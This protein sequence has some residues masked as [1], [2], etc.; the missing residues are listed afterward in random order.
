MHI[1]HIIK[2]ISIHKQFIKN[3]SQQNVV[4]SNREFD[5]S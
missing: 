3:Y 1:I 5:I 4:L 2:T